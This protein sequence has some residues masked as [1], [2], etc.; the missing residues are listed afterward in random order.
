M[1]NSLKRFEKWFDLKLSWFFING[2]KQEAW[3][4]HLKEKY[5]EEY[6]TSE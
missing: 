5:P 3:Q 2:H 1:K 6:K 4:E